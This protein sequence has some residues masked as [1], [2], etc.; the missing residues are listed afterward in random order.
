MADRP[1]EGVMRL[2]DFVQRYETQGPLEII[3]GEVRALP[4]V[5]LDHSDAAKV[6]YDAI[7]LYTHGRRMGRVYLETAF[8]LPDSYDANWVKGSRV[9]DVMFIMQARWEE[10]AQS[11]G[12]TMKGKPLMLVPD[13][14]VEI[15]SPN[16]QRDALSD[17]AKR[18]LADG[19]Q[20]IWIV[21]Q[22]RETVDVYRP[23]E[24]V[25]SVTKTLNADSIIPGFELAVRAIFAG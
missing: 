12:E 14:V 22:A 20:L 7:L 1:A 15:K 3:D 19:V 16:D 4:P 23:G 6:I 8:I 2:D 25:D 9:P 13:L 17:K 5:I 21:D 11:F 10:Y 24:P 18:Y